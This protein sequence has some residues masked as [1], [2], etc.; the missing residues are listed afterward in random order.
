MNASRCA[1]RVPIPA[2]AWLRDEVVDGGL[3]TASR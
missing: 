2:A 1:V 3:S